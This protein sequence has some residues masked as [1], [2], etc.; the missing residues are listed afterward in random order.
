MGHEPGNVE[1]AIEGLEHLAEEKDEV[2]LGDV[3]DEF[4]K[5][6]FGPL[7]MI[8]ALM[9]LTPLGAIPGFPTVLATLCALIA[10]QLLWGRDH[11]WVPGFVEKRAVASDKLMK[12]A[13][14]LEGFAEKLDHWF[15]GRLQQFIKPPWPRIAAVAI[16]LLCLTV[17]PLEF[18]PF[19][20]SAPMLA[21][22]A[23]GLAL[24]VRD[25]LLM[26]IA[27]GLSGVALGVG[28]WLYY[29]SDSGSGGG[30]GLF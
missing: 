25:G 12:S 26:L 9:E 21:I 1:E 18:V 29:T 22:T 24:T 10:V 28:T 14:K 15:M 2:T 7:L 3:L 16:L 20:S 4:G 13:Q 23:F 8:F 5:R 19:A 17:P 11:I 27:L 30:M 6:S